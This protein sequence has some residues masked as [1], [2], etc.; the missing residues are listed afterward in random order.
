MIKSFFNQKGYEYQ[1][2]VSLKPYNTYRIDINAKYIVFPK[3]KDEL[4]NLLK[5][6]KNN[7]IKYLVL[8]N[9]SN[10]ILAMDYYDG[11]IIKLDHLNNIAINKDE[12]T[13]EAGYFL[14]KL[15]KEAAN[16]SLSGLEFASG[17][18]GQLGASIAM[19]AG[20]YNKDMASAVTSVTVI[21]PHLEIETLL[22]QDLDFKYRS[23]FLKENNN[24]IVTK[25]VLK[26]TKGNKEEILNLMQDRQKRRLAS[27]PLEYPNSGSVFRNPKDNFAGSLIE[28]CHLKNYHINDA[29]VSEKHANFIINKG[30]ATGQDI[31]NLIEYIQKEVQKKYNIELIVEQKIIK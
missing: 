31:V 8:G 25:A 24:Y 7:K 17:I 30:H 19:N 23:S 14:P 29:Y 4:L 11:V 9:G 2:E 18:P 20:A 26:L 13:V 27:Q 5:Y 6:L 1:E 12:I 10:I 22:P 21:N 15:A 28:N 16:N 3:N